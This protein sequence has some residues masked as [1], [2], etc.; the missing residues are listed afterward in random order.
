MSSLTSNCQVF[1]SF[2]LLHKPI[3]KVQASLYQDNQI[4]VEKIEEDS[5]DSIPSPSPSVKIQIIGGRVYLNEIIR[6]N[7]AG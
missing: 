7:I 1:L 4:K 2:I 6:Q 3:K 5:L